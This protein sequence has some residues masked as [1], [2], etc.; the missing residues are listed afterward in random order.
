M[1]ADEPEERNRV[2]R[3][4]RNKCLLMAKKY[5]W[6]VVEHYKTEPLAENSDDEKKIRK[7]IK[8]GRAKK[9]IGESNESEEEGYLKTLHKFKQTLFQSHTSSK[10]HFSTK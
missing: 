9:N 2:L 1:E 10:C 7:A 3:E 5:G 4:H 6:D 8:E